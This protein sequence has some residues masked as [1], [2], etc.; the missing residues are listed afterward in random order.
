MC[1]VDRTNK[2]NDQKASDATGCFLLDRISGALGWTGTS[3]VG[4][5]G[6][7]LVAT[8]LLLPPKCCFSVLGLDFSL[9]K[10]VTFYPHQHCNRIDTGDGV[11]FNA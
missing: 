10:T 7:E 11:S 2:Q 6:F 1:Q 8:L 9:S 4:Q 5:A 3:S